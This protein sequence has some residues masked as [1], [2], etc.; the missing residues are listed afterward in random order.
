M[1][2]SADTSRKEHCKVAS[3]LTLGVLNMFIWVLYRSSRRIFNA[4]W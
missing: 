3:V 2:L 4:A 1:S